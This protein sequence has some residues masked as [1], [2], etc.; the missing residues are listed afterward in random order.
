MRFILD[1][2]CILNTSV[3]DP[4]R[5]TKALRSSCTFSVSVFLR[6]RR[7]FEGH[8][9]RIAVGRSQACPKCAKKCDI[10]TPESDPKDIESLHQSQQVIQLLAQHCFGTGSRDETI[11]NRILSSIW[12]SICQTAMRN[13]LSRA[14]V[15]P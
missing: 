8:P 4:Q 1:P 6:R 15:S 9:S 2:Y 13:V 5:T 11:E 12:S 10:A 3:L 14:S 7:C